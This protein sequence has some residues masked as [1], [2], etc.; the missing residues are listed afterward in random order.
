M[1]A[2]NLDQLKEDVNKRGWAL[3]KLMVQELTKINTLQV[4]IFEAFRKKQ[5]ANHERVLNELTKKFLTYE[6]QLSN[7][8]SLVTTLKGPRVTLNLRLSLGIICDQ[9]TTQRYMLAS[10]LKEINDAVQDRRNRANNILNLTVTV[11]IASVSVV[12]SVCI[13]LLSK[14]LP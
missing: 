6:E 1:S 12:I 10:L 7:Y 14:L 13:F 3:R 2:I 11:A 8:V 4:G 5:I 9:L